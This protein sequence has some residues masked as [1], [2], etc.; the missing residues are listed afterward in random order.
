MVKN[1][2]LTYNSN[3]GLSTLRPI[4][5]LSGDCGWM[6]HQLFFILFTVVLVNL[7]NNFLASRT[8]NCSLPKRT[9]PIKR[10]LSESHDRRHTQNISG[11]SSSYDDF[12]YNGNELYSK[13]YCNTNFGSNCERWNYDWSLFLILII[14]NNSMRMYFSYINLKWWRWKKQQQKNKQTT[15]V[16]NFIYL[17]I[18][19]E[20][21]LNI[22]ESID[23]A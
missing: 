15:K 10:Q 16:I 17:T 14:H 18:K 5:R 4:F 11:F 22:F 9:M 6:P 1:E 8:L 21:W 12:K 19:R 2:E 3:A 23:G 7:T 20:D 13:L